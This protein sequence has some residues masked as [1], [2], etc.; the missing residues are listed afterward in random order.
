MMK[1]RRMWTVLLSVILALGMTV[2]ASAEELPGTVVG[3]TLLTGEASS[4]TQVFLV[5]GDTIPFVTPVINDEPA[6]TVPGARKVTF[7]NVTDMMPY[8]TY[9]AEGGCSITK[10]QDNIAHVGAYTRCYR[11]AESVYVGL[12]V[13][14]LKNGYWHTIW[15]DEAYG[16]NTYYLSYSNS[17]FVTPGYYYRVTAIHTADNGSVHEG[18]ES[19]SDGVYF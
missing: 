11:T 10:V 9:L 3:G 1:K 8:G 14:Q 5:E 17:I 4:S 16:S 6:K 15:F 18:N 7:G 12:S 13:D 2:L 19:F